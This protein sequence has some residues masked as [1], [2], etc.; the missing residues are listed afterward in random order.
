M[1]NTILALVAVMLV[2][3]GSVRAADAPP[4]TKRPK[5]V[6]ADAKKFGGHFYKAYKGGVSWDE[7]Q[8]R[9]EKMGGYLACI[10]SEEENAFL[11]RMVS[12]TSYYVG[13]RRGARGWQWVDGTA[14][15]YTNWYPGEPTS[16]QLE[17]IAAQYLDA[18]ESLDRDMLDDCLSALRAA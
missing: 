8:K 12:G 14:F 15:G 16:T 11:G 2:C 5:N 18:I 3:G 9:C 7:A 4:A 1:R 13:G 6:P 17:P 10:S